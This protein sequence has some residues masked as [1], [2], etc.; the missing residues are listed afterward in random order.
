MTAEEM[1]IVNTVLERA[2]GQVECWL[3][4]GIE[5]A[6]HQFTGAIDSPGKKE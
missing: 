3:A 4:A 6:M 1:K 5:K 2:A